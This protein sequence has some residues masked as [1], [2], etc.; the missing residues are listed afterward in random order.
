MGDHNTIYELQNYVVAASPEGF[1]LRADGSLDMLQSFKRVD[2]FALL[3][4]VK[5]RNNVQAEAGNRPIDFVAARIPRASILPLLSEELQF[6]GDCLWIYG[7]PEH[8]ALIL[9]RE[10]RSGSVSLRYLPI[11]DLRMDAGGRI[12][13]ERAPW[14]EGLPLRFWED[15]NLR[16]PSDTTREAFLDGWHTDVEWL[17]V[18]HKTDYSNG[19]I[20]IYEQLARHTPPSL[21]SNAE[22]LSEDERLL[23]R[24]RRRQRALAETD[25]L[26]LANNHW[27][28]DVRGF[29]PGG[30]HG[31]FFRVSTNSTLMFWG[32]ESTNVPRGAIVEEPYDSLSFVPTVLALTGQLSDGQRPVPILWE[33]G[34]RPFPGRPVQEVLARGAQAPQ[35][36]AKG[37]GSQP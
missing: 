34:F 23:R 37:D 25:L 27:N 24:F 10:D 1:K 6:D 11:K 35:P 28:F 32:G 8:Q 36:V 26:I 21:D 13:F 33:R 19:L 5:V 2:Y 3:H 14:R 20:G 12:S 29:N 4:A 16:I 30:N 15:K 18:L 9:G 7:G 17:R 22:G 31:S